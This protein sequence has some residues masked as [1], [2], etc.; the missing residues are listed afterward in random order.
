MPVVKID[1][2]KLKAGLH[3]YFEAD[4]FSETLKELKE[5][6]RVGTLIV[7]IQEGVVVVE[8][9]A[10]DAGEIINGETKH[11]ALAQYVDDCI[12]LPFFLE[13]F[14]GKLIHAGIHALV[15][16]Y[17]AKWGHGWIEKLKDRI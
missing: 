7:L 1:L 3:D 10:A 4:K 11:E 2:E 16:W 17:N 8:K 13:P 5:R 15:A 6:F 14:D 9:L 12:S